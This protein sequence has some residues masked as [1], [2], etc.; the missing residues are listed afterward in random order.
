M[1]DIALLSL[2]S[3]VDVPLVSRVPVLHILSKTLAIFCFKTQLEWDPTWL[4][5]SE[6]TITSQT[7]AYLGG[8][9]NA[10]QLR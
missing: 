9:P 2:H 7:L 6:V 8:S 4:A 3:K 10:G 5:H 1:K